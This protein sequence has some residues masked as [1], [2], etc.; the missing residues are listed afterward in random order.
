[1]TTK[2][3]LESKNWELAHSWFVDLPLVYAGVGLG[4][5]AVYSF[6]SVIGRIQL[7]EATQE[8]KADDGN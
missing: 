5:L 8:V 1:M 4:D 3:E 2:A 6:L 7:S